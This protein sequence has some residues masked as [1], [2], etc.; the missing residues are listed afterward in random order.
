[1]SKQND[2]SVQSVVMPLPDVF[3]VI[4]HPSLKWK[5]TRQ[6][7]GA[8]LR[9]V[10]RPGGKFRSHDS[11]GEETARVWFDEADSVWVPVVK[12]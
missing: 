9:E 8:W 4:N 12:A 7:N 6:A 2:A 11:V 3:L 1:M 10:A 5:F